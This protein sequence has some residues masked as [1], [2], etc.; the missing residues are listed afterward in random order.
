MYERVSCICVPWSGSARHRCD[1]D[2]PSDMTKDDDDEYDVDTQSILHLHGV[3]RMHT[4]E[5]RRTVERTDGPNDVDGD[6][7]HNVFALFGSKISIIFMLPMRVLYARIQ[8]DIPRHACTQHR[9]ALRCDFP[10]RCV[11]SLC[12][13]RC[14]VQHKK[15]A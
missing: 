4:H 3:H 1:V 10:K 6:D 8:T 5:P 15:C 9:T 11:R 7:H 2:P 13:C 14:D 12:I